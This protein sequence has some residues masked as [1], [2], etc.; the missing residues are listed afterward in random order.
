MP[1]PGNLAAISSMAATACSRLSAARRSTRPDEKSYSSEPLQQIA[2]S[3]SLRSPS[4]ALTEAGGRPEATVSRP[5]M[6]RNS[7][8]TVRLHSGMPALAVSS[9]LSISQKTSSSWS[10]CFIC[11]I[12][13]SAVAVAVLTRALCGAA[14]ADSL[15]TRRATGFQTASFPLWPG[16]GSRVPWR[17]GTAHAAM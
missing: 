9:V 15:Q 17:A 2:G 11:E 1:M 6:R 7:C 10:L 16:A 3:E 8:M 13:S 14:F 5:P 4:A 12:P